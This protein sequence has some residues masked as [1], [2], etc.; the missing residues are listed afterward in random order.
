MMRIM[1]RGLKEERDG[2][3]GYIAHPHREEQGP[4][5]LM[6]HQHSGLTGYLKTAAYRFAQLG[7]TTVIP[8]LYEMLGYP[9]ETHIDKGTEIQNKT[10]D[11]DFV[12]VIDRGWRYALARPDVDPSRAGV[13]GYCMGGRLGIHFV[14]ATPAVRAF[15]AYYPSVKDEQPTRIRPRHPCDAAREIKCPSMVLYGGKDSTSTI[16]IQQRV[17]ESFYANGQP[18]EWHY[19]DF[20]NHGFASTESDGYQPYLADLVWPLVT[21]FLRRELIS[22]AL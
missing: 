10:P 7:F 6:I 1:T 8:N 17:M 22:S 4:A 12:R 20:G 5:L 21:E 14:A 18:L 16:P 11:P 19:F 2:I 3:P 9:A 15:V 13:I